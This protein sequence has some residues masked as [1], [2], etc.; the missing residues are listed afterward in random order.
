VT[1][2]ELNQLLT[3]S[4]EATLVHVLP[5]EVFASR[6]IPGSCNACVYEMVF[7][8]K[9][10]EIAPNKTA[11]IVVY[12]AGEGSLDSKT[13]G[14][15]LQA[16]GYT[17]VRVFDDGLAG[18]KKAGFPLEGDGSDCGSVI[19]NGNYIADTTESV[20]R[21]TG[22][23]LFNHHHGTVS[24]D[25]G[26]LAIVDGE[27]RSAR[28]AVDMNRIA[29]EDLTD[30]TWNAMLIRHL[31]DADFFD[32]AQ[33]PLSTF[34]AES[35]TPITDF[36]PGTPTHLLRGRFTLRGVTQ[37]L[38]IPIVVA[39]AGDRITAQAQ[40]ELDRTLF[41]SLYGSGK[42]FQFL[43]KHVVNDHIHLHLKI[44]ADRKV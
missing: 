14:E 37:T 11:P 35:V 9:L 12:G 41:G 26:E 39:A 19:A 7:G 42:F 28:F 5:E 2:T 43:G 15:K 17:N 29:C 25:S 23:N 24:L 6:R 40:F 34:T 4:P 8:E 1:A 32:V 22:R 44:H 16:L 18:W 36:T 27:L 31:R 20:I 38:E 33:H 3:A 21:W 10:S 30:S 13:A